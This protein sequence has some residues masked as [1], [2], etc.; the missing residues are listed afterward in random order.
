MS[1]NKEK[2]PIS[3][4]IA[5]C[6]EGH[7]L[8][9]CLKS[10]AFCDEIYFVNLGSTDKSVEIAKKYAT[11]II[12][13]Q[14][15]EMIEEIFPKFIP[16]LQND[17]VLLIDPDERIDTLLQLDIIKFLKDLPSDCGKINAPIRYYYKQKAL[18][19][20]VWGGNKHGR[21]LIRKSACLIGNKVHIAISLKDGFKQYKIEHKGDNVNHHYWVQSFDQML[22]KHKRYTQKEGKAKYSKGERYS[23]YK[24]IQESIRSFNDCFF[25]YKGYLDGLTGFFLSLFYA[26]YQWSSMLSL[27]KYQKKIK[28]GSIDRIANKK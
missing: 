23:V 5:S 12:E 2:L 15:V 14:K 10:L 13:Y 6:N 17:W 11:K 16:K 24:L 18:K 26:W 22:E 9:D 20:T 25:K 7:L 4:L 28:N 21:L 8:E 27:K 3:V 19:G 1:D